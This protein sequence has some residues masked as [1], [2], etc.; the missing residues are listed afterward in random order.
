MRYA[1]VDIE[2]TGGHAAGCG[3]TEIAILI[4][5]GTGVVDRFE[6]LVNPLQPIPVYIQSFTGIDDD[7]VAAAP[8]FSD[9]AGRIYELLS[10]CVFVAHNVNFDYSFVKHQ[11]QQEGYEFSAPKLCTV[12]LS[13]KIRPGLP[14]YSLG[15][16][17]ESLQLPL[18]N[19]HRAGGDA[20]ATALLFTQ[21][22]SWDTEGHIAAMLKRNSKEQALPPNLPR[23]VFLAL[24]EGPGV[25]YFRDQAGKVIY[26]GKANNI[27]KRVSSHF[28]GHNPNPQRQHFLKEI[29]GIS[30]ESC[31]T[32]LMALLLE[33]AEIRQ[34][35]PRYNRALKR[36][37]PA[38]GLYVYEDR[39]DALRLAVGK[40]SKSQLAV[41]EF[42]S[43]EEGVSMLH[44]LARRFELCPDLCGLGSCRTECYD[45]VARPGATAHSSVAAHNERVTAA[46]AYL[47]E[48]LPTFA[49]LDKGRDKE[50]QSLVWVEKGRFHA[51]GYVS[52]HHDLQATDDIRDA[53]TRYS[54]NHYSMQL[55]Y[56]FAAKHPGKV[57]RFGGGKTED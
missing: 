12:R 54:S 53:L 29:Y 20:A 2:T 3:I 18:E 1:I 11:L 35:W 8:V 49:L 46:L 40:Y 45:L 5:D 30:Y 10:G 43:Q 27:K 21:L 36:F 19:R 52:G 17:C 9:V 14:S 31:A 41:H 16:L 57:L 23:E 34:L 22:I 55:I 51:M 33:A 25:Y 47:Q 50:E 37:E 56:S 13:R 42:N 24:P 7:M 28:T 32:E 44:R 38:F 15:R 26:V 6:T 39:N 48:Q 4:H